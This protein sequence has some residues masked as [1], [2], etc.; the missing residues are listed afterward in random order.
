VDLQKSLEKSELKQKGIGN[1]KISIQMRRPVRLGR[2][3]CGYGA[4]Y[5]GRG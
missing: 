5:G 1:A 3:F 2:E 4:G